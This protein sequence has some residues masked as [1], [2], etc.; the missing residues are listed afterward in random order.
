MLSHQLTNLKIGG[1][2]CRLIVGTNLSAARNRVLLPNLLCVGSEALP[3]EQRHCQERYRP[4]HPLHSTA[5]S[6]AAR[7]ISSLARDRRV[8]TDMFE[9]KSMVRPPS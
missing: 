4:E 8:A 2:E 1:E 3:S 7:R 6:F 5:S 9:R